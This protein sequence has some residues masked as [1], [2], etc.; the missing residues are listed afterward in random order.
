MKAEYDDKCYSKHKTKETVGKSGAGAELL[1]YWIH[2][3]KISMCW[4]NEKPVHRQHIG[5]WKAIKQQGWVPK[6]TMHDFYLQ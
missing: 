2:E 6:E 4:L 5:K 1:N 3:I